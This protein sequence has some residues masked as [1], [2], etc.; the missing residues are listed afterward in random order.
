MADRP[1]SINSDPRI[2]RTIIEAP[3]SPYAEAVRSLKLTV[4]LNRR[5][6][7]KHSNVIGL[8]SCLPSEGKSTLSAA[9]AALMADGGSRVLLVDCDLRNPSLSRTLTPDARAGFLDV[10][11]GQVPLADAVWTDPTTN[12]SFLPMVPNRRLPNPTEMLCSPAAKSLFG[13]LEIRYDYVVVDLSPL[14]A[15]V[16]ARAAARLINS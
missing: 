4:D 5:S 10:V 3:W 11:A 15:T 6:I 1:R 12:L 13:A 2:L 9:M 7:G 8:T 16:D 14:V